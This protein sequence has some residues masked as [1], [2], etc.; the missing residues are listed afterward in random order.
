MSGNGIISGDLFIGEGSD[1]HEDV[2]IIRKG[3]VTGR[4]KSREYHLGS[5]VQPAEMSLSL[6]ELNYYQPLFDAKMLELG[7]KVMTGMFV[8][9]KARKLFSLEPVEKVGTEGNWA[10]MPGDPV[11]DIISAKEDIERPAGYRERTIGE[12]PSV[13][14]VVERVKGILKGE[15]DPGEEAH[16]YS[17]GLP[18]HPY[19][20]GF[21]G[22]F[23]KLNPDGTI[24]EAAT[25]EVIAHMDKSKYNVYKGVKATVEH[26][27]LGMTGPLKA[28]ITVEETPKIFEPTEELKGGDSD[29][30]VDNPDNGIDD[31]Q[32]SKKHGADKEKADGL[33]NDI[34][35]VHRGEAGGRTDVR[36]G[37]PASKKRKKKARKKKVLKKEE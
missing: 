10:H 29:D 37:P 13:E 21:G 12:P 31:R 11:A 6:D 26:T 5:M 19:K 32:T 14:D 1:L 27:D 24:R 30:H 17:R 16:P 23:T 18:K 2:F 34:L 33:D 35:I 4:I 3:Q 9:D 7:M 36:S 15:E 22:G 8:S 25:D 28:T 20:R